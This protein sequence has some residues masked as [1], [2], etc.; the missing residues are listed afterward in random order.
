MPLLALSTW[1][2][3]ASVGGQARFSWA[4][5][6]DFIDGAEAIRQLNVDPGR[7]IVRVVFQRM[8]GTELVLHARVSERSGG[9][10]EA[11]FDY[12]FTR[13]PKAEKT[14]VA[15]YLEE[16]LGRPIGSSQEDRDL[17]E[18]TGT[19]IRSIEVSGRAVRDGN[20]QLLVKS[21]EPLDMSGP[22]MPVAMTVKATKLPA[23]DPWIGDSEGEPS[24]WVI[25]YTIKGVE[26][27]YRYRIPFRADPD[28]EPINRV[29]IH[30]ADWQYDWSRRQ[31][32]WGIRIE[33]R[34]GVNSPF[35]GFIELDD[36]GYPVDA[37]YSHRAFFDEELKKRLT[38]WYRWSLRLRNS[39]FETGGAAW[40]S[41]PNIAWN[42]SELSGIVHELLEST[43]N[44][45]VRLQVLEVIAQSAVVRDDTIPL[46][47]KSL[48]ATNE[49]EA[50]AASRILERHE[51]EKARRY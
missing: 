24:D 23:D 12:P 14:L 7:L 25:D 48:D 29:I 26:E 39:E 3:L 9:F 22:K 45:D 20:L 19:I 37:H 21:I 49:L 33:V 2:W 17:V 51:M 47:K 10:K 28:V 1:L 16:K 40:R 36:Y 46:V 6:D 5:E 41:R 4:A 43:D 35:Y 13:R 42:R 44:A 34:E 18:R 11:S 31:H 50:Q 8:D 15:E 30:D 27:S 32:K 38:P